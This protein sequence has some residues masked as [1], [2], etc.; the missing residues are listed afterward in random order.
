MEAS[1]IQLFNALYKDYKDRFIHFAKT[2]VYRYE[3]AEDIVMESLMDYWENRATLREGSHIPTY[4]LT[5]I[6]NKCLNY[7]QRLHTWQD[8]EA[9]LAQVEAWELEVQISTLEAC[10]PHRLFSAEIQEII[11][12]TMLTMP[13][14]TQEIFTRSKYHKQSHKEI[15]DALGISDKSVEYH[16]NKSLK[17]LRVALGDYFP[18]LFFIHLS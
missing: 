9:H 1:D 10:D 17:V 3:V 7:L 5:I 15:A 6:K 16:L 13:E 14:Q 18:L 8:I 12:K 2:Y 4:V 11:D